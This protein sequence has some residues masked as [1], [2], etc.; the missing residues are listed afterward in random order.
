MASLT[1]FALWMLTWSLGGWLFV[2][3]GLRLPRRYRWALG[4]A[5]GLVS[6]VWL[7]NLLARL[8]PV[9]AAFW[10]AAVAILLLGLSVTPWRKGRALAA[11]LSLSPTQTLLFLALAALFTAIGRGLNLFDDYQNLP[12][13]SL[14]ATGDIPPHF[15]FDPSLTFGYHYLLLLFAAQLVRLGDLFPWSALDLARGLTFSLTL[16]LASLWAFRLTRSRA[17]ALLGLV[18]F[19]LAGGTRW[20]LL[21]LPSATLEQLS[22]QVTLLGSAQ[23]TVATL[24]NGLTGLWNIDGSGPIPF[25]FIFLSGVNNPLILALSGMGTLPFL[26]LLSILFFQRSARDPWRDLAILIFLSALALSNEVLYL[27]WLAGLGLVLGIKIFRQ[28]RWRPEWARWLVVSTLS[29]L[30]ALLQGGVLSSLRQGLFVP[31]LEETRAAYHTFQFGLSGLPTLISGHLGVLNLLNPWHLFLALLEI[32]PILLALPLTF[33][34][35][36]KAARARHDWEAAFIAAALVG[37]L[38]LFLK[39]SGTAGITAN[40]RLNGLLFLPATFYAFPLAWLWGCRRSETLRLTLVTLALITTFSGTIL[41]GLELVAMQKPLFPTGMQELD[42][43]MAKRHWNQLPSGALIADPLPMRGVTVL[44]RPTRSH[45]TWYVERPEWQDLLT[46]PDPY[47]LQAAG[48]DYLYFDI[49]Y[50][51]TLIPAD[52]AALQASCVRVVDEVR[53]YRSEKDFRRDFRRLL[54]L[55]ACH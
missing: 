5:F 46:H 45:L 9:P 47:R 51:E 8:F 42:A 48:F 41:L 14:L 19:A 30:F 26:I 17:A 2:T 10:L 16:L 50:W 31:D 3:F 38:S 34:W 55:R 29:L 44:G 22:A 35:G 40:S 24:L 27:A 12:T 25:P 6:Q 53:G 7:A 21:L 13:V 28:R 1:L 20:L 11:A 49:A 32:G 54:D 52:Q 39:Y 33:A 37:V 36:W 4:M 15:A 18:F 43:R 23:Q